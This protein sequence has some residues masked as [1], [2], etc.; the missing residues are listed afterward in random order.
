ML[1]SVLAEFLKLP[2][3]LFQPDFEF[4][5]TM[6][7]AIPIPML[8]ATSHPVVPYVSYHCV[9]IGTDLRFAYS[10]IKAIGSLSSDVNL[11]SITL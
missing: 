3:Y 2:V 4:T 7:M 11:T 6:I 9:E 8:F 1:G 5:Q 10:R